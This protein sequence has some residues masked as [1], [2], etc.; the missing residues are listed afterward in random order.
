MNESPST[1]VAAVSAEKPVKIPSLP[2]R[3]LSLFAQDVGNV[4]AALTI[5]LVKLAIAEGEIARFFAI[6]FIMVG[7]ILGGVKFIIP[8]NTQDHSLDFVTPPFIAIFF[9]PAFMRLM[10]VVAG[11]FSDLY[12]EA[13]GRQ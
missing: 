13:K 7:A 12:H 6:A 9:V 1:S 3:I 4:L 10:I 11:Y 2:R 8:P 5:G